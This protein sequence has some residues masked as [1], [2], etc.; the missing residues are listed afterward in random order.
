MLYKKNRSEKLEQ[1][2]FE[3]PTSEYRAAP[4]WAW[5]CQLGKEELEWQME[6]F[7]QM[8]FGGAHMHVRTGMATP[9]LSEEHMDLIKSCVAKAKK[10]GML[11]WLYDEDRWPSGPAGGIVTK[12]R[13]Y[14]A[15]YLLFTPY[16]YGSKQAEMKPTRNSGTVQPGRTECGRLLACFDVEL[17]ENGYLVQ[18]KMIGETED[19]DHEKWYAYLEEMGEISWWNGQT[20]VNSLDKSA[21]DRFI[22]VTYETYR[23][24]ISEEFARTVPAIFTDE[25]QF[26]RKTTLQ[27]ATEKKDVTIAWTDDLAD[28]Y[29]GMYPDENLIAGIPEL[30]WDRADRVPSVI[31]CHYH[32]HV[33]ER[34][35]QAFTDNCG[36]W[37]KEHGL[38]LTGHVMEEPTLKSQTSSL[39]E[40]MRSYRGFGIPGI[41]MLSAKFEFTTVKQA[42]SVVHQYEKEGMLSELYGVTGWDFDFRGHKLHG[43][44]QAALGVTVRVPHLSWVSMG[45]ESKRDYP[46]SIHYQSPWWDRY[47]LVEDHFARV[48]TAMSR[49]KAVVKVG[50]IH[51][52]ESYWL[53]F[54]PAEQ[55]ATIRDDLDENFQNITKWLLLGTV[56]FDFI[57]ESLLPELCESGDYPL[58][59]GAMKYEVVIVPNCETLRSTTLE[60][61]ERFVQNGGKLIFAGKVPVLE[62]ACASHRGIQLAEHAAKIP[63]QKGAVLDAVEEMRFLEIRDESGAMTNN[64]VHQIRTDGEGRWL[65]IAHASEPRNKHISEKQNVTIRIKGNWTVTLY[66]TL[67]G[68]T[69]ILE[70]RVWRNVTEFYRTL[71]AYDSLLLW[72]QPAEGNAGVQE[73]QPTISA[74]PVGR[75]Q[76]LAVPDVVPYTL[77]EPNALLLDQA[78]YALDGGTWHE[79]EELLRVDIACRKMLGWSSDIAH[80]AQ[81]WSLG[82]ETEFHKVSLRF[83]IFSD[84]EYEGARLAVEHAGQTVIRWNGKT[85]TNEA[86]GWY[87]D[88][89]IQTILIPKIQK[90]ENLLEVD[91]PIGKRTMVEWMYLLGD[92]GVEVTGK[93]AKLIAKRDQLAF[94]D[95][96][97]QGLPFYTGNVTYHMDVETESGE[98]YIR[99][100]FYIGAMQEARVNGHESKPLIFPPYKISLGQVA[101]G[102]HRVDL[103]FYGNRQNG[104]GALHLAD[105]KRPYLN[106]SSWRTAGDEW[107]YEYMLKKTGVMVTPE[108]T[109]EKNI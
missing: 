13:K 105:E 73:K 107:C 29:E 88:K 26:P 93:H 102:K 35:V 46:A 108:I 21:I 44:W 8:G 100:G 57:S 89:A 99:S 43:D 103:T 78:E 32:D 84:I 50:V 9:Y 7:K 23:R 92:F 87:V 90:G 101:E 106:P 53:H 104:F 45:G 10:E 74:K 76:H 42:Q 69:E 91:V 98:L 61:L 67:N 18:S 75:T 47:S 1:S 28:T 60:R 30:I 31:R 25:P 51:P 20:Y 48:C 80:V 63:F 94:G 70:R 11:A 27:Y 16:P 40:A 96:T 34:F 3:S 37:C 83:W 54:G 59:V 36:A 65:F 33:C 5:N 62:E 97:V 52:I 109:L 55:T 86:G 71:Y 95:L 17:D 85:V 2:L 49:G 19:A 22:E 41:D 12:D 82:H 66:D 64:L 24:T 38:A 68:E 14:R 56:D 58:Q 79:K 81:P 72:L 6:I 15:R 39:G 4:F 77:S